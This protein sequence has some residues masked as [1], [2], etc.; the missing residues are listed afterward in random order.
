MGKS[1]PDLRNTILKKTT[2]FA[3]QFSGH[4]M[5][6][7]ITILSYAIDTEILIA[8]INVWRCCPSLH[9]YLTQKLVFKMGAFEFQ[10]SS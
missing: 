7:I 9:V 8:S 3:L 5:T 6:R 10:T 4:M 2:K 1:V